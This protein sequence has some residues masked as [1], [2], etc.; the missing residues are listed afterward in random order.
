MLLIFDPAILS[1]DSIAEAGPFASRI[2][3]RQL[4]SDVPALFQVRKM[5]PAYNLQNV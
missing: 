3:A 5:F 1:H 4:E 2:V